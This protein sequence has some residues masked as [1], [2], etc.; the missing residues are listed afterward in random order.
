MP[1]PSKKIDFDLDFLDKNVKEKPKQKPNFSKDPNRVF[2]DDKNKP[3][4]DY[5]KGP[6]KTWMW[7]L[8]VIVLSVV[9]GIFLGDSNNTSTT[10][11]TNNG[12]VQVGQYMC[13]T[14][15]ADQA[16]N[17]APS[18]Y[19]KS[20]LDS[21]SSKLDSRGTALD[22]EKFQIKN[23]YVDETNQYN[24]DAYNAKVDDYNYRFQQ[25]ENDL[26]SYNSSVNAYNTKID[27]Y[28]NYLRTNCTPK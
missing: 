28:N 20:S 17:M 14:Y 25:Y 3:Y 22:S 10:S 6:S 23:E 2:Y 19:Q 16:D 5:G 1:E 24:I 13:S 7:V 11:P 12:L 15:Y 4:N 18:S 27:A 26:S 8:G 21:T 9:V